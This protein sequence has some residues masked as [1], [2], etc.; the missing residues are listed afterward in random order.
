MPK[1]NSW[2]DPQSVMAFS[3]FGYKDAT[4]NRRISPAYSFF[5]RARVIA[6]NQL[7]E[8]IDY[9]NR[10]HQLM[11]CLMSKGARDNEDAQSFGYRFDDGLTQRRASASTGVIGTAYGNS[12]KQKWL[13]VLN[14]CLVYSISLSIFL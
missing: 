7:V 14:L 3:M 2:L 11:S 13:L 1:R 6:G 10:N 9:Y 5:K 12:S 8:D 4:D